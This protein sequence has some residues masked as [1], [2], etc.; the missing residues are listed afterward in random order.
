MGRRVT[1]GVRPVGRPTAFR[2]GGWGRR[3]QEGKERGGPSF[4]SSLLLLYI[5]IAEAY[6]SKGRRGQDSPPPP[7]PPVR[8]LQCIQHRSWK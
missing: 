4:P 5:E 6:V 1:T 7:P 8:L 2:L 3:K